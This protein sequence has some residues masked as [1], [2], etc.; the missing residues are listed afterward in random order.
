VDTKIPMRI[1]GAVGFRPT[2]PY[3]RL[4][5]QTSD[6]VSIPIARSISLV[7]SV[8]LTP[9][10]C[11]ILNLKPSFLFQGCSVTVALVPRLFMFSNWDDKASKDLL[12]LVQGVV[13][14]L[15]VNF[16][17]DIE[18]NASDFK[19]RVIR[20]FRSELPSRHGRPRIDTVTRA[21]ETPNQEKT[22]QQIYVECLAHDMS[23]PDSRQVAQSRLR[24]AVRVRLKSRQRQAT[25]LKQPIR[26]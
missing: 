9:K 15:S 14:H 8:V 3:P 18:R 2:T 26:E 7:D 16:V 22:W 19:R 1:Y 4:K 5:R 11:W 17:S 13:R 10:N 21:A 24:S 25:T 20:F 6:V 23:G 12:T